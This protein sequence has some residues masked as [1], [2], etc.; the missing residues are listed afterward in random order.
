M[1]LHVQRLVE[2]GGAGM[3][4]LSALDVW[5]VVSPLMMPIGEGLADFALDARHAIDAT[6]T[7]RDSATT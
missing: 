3:G 5:G 4:E 7:E 2:A 1:F 6:K